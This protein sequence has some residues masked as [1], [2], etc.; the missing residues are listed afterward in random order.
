MK[1]TG[2]AHSNEWAPLLQK[3]LTW[4]TSKLAIGKASTWKRRRQRNNSG[5]VIALGGTTDRFD[6]NMH[7]SGKRA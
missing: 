4:R 1:Q 3:L 2:G 5:K 7:P 6:R